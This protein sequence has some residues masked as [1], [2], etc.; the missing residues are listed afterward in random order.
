[1]ARIKICRRNLS[2]AALE[3]LLELLSGAGC[4]A[5]DIELVDE[6]G[7]PLEE[8][9]DQIAIF[10]L[11]EATC[12]QPEFEEQMNNT[13]TAGCRAICVWPEGAASFDLPE[14]VRKYAYS[15]VS[16][17]AERLRVAL[18][19]DDVTCFETPTGTPW[20]AEEIKRHECK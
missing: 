20:T 10:V 1:M 5:A 9:L 18:A 8:V 12:G 19:D 13:P 6:I 7:P 16:W 2:Q 3:G 11:D 14:S 17:N 15:I 4:L